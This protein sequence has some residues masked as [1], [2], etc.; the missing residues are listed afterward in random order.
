MFGG[1]YCLFALKMEGTRS[2]KMLSVT[3]QIIQCYKFHV[4]DHYTNLHY[5]ENLTP[6]AVCICSQHGE[7]KGQ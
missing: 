2:P 4:E 6:G 5:H 1:T 7:L 3:Y